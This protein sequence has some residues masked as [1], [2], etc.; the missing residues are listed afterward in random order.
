MKKLFRNGL[1]LTVLAFMLSA[2]GGIPAAYQGEFR[3]DALGASMKLSGSEGIFTESDGLAIKT[4]AIALS[5]E[6]LMKGKPG[7]YL[8]KN[9]V[10]Q[11]LIDVYWIQPRFTERQEAGGLVWY[12][13]EVYYTLVSK[14]QKQKVPSIKMI[15]SEEGMVTL[16]PGTKSWQVGW[17]AQPVEYNLRRLK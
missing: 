4:P 16:E 8:R 2:C 11:D 7:I 17:P 14:T 6:A 12:P 3:D 1:L 10:R 5:F 13:S 9:P 15:F